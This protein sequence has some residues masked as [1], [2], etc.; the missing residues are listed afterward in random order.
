MMIEANT[1]FILH[2]FSFINI[3]IGINHLP[4]AVLQA[5]FVLTLISSFL[6]WRLVF[7]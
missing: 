2:P 6:Y 1:Y 3:F 7:L 5:V 4:N